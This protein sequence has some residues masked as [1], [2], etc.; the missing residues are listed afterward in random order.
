MSATPTDSSTP[1]ETATPVFTRTPSDT[2]TWTYTP[3]L[4]FTETTTL[5]STPT[6]TPTFE[7]LSQPV[8]FPNPATG[9]GSVHLMVPLGAVSDVSVRLFTLAFGR[10]INGSSLKSIRV[11]RVDIPLQIAKDAHF[12]MGFI[13]FWLKPGD[14]GGRSSF[15]SC[16]KEKAHKK[17]PGMFFEIDG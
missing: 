13:I 17:I 4:T 15:S 5:S 14:K 3:T 9:S 7:V 2:S 8:I 10:R 16:G 11:N 12:P 6:S 1:T